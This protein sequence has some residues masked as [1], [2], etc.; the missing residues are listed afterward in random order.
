VLQSGKL[1]GAEEA[2]AGQFGYSATLSADGNT[3]VVGGALDAGAVGAAWVFTRTGSTWSQQGAKRTGSGERGTGWFGASAALSGDATIAVIGGFHD[4]NGEG[5]VWVF[6]QPTVK[7]EETEKE[8]EKEEKEKEKEKGKEGEPPK[9]PHES[10]NPGPTQEK[11][12]SGGVLGTVTESLPAPTLA[13]NG[14]LRPISGKVRIKLPGTNVWILVTGLRQVP[15]GTIIDARHGKFS[16]TTA[17][18]HGGTQ[19]V[20]I[21]EGEVKIGQGRNGRVTLTLVGGNFKNCPTASQR[22]H[23]LAHIARRR[24][25]TVRKLWAEGHGSYTTKGNYASGAVLGTRWVTI[26]YCEGT[27]IRVLT[28]KVSVHDFVNGHR[29]VVKAGHSYFAKA[30]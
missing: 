26:D 1:T 5:A 25:R 2:G 23:R 17:R 13:V 22:R 24:R 11:I 18:R 19:T 14:N 20:T 9:E 12:S 27:L 6:H 3:A 16:L 8:K 15:F 21:Y 29:H 28:D 4:N 10:G 7:E 30:P